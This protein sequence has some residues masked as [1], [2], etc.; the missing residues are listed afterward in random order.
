MPADAPGSHNITK[1]AVAYAELRLARG[2]SEALFAGYEERVR[3]YREAG[4]N[5]LLADEYWLRGRAALALGQYDTALEH[6][7]EAGETAEAQEER[8]VLWKILASLAEVE[9]ACGN[10]AA[11][12]RL[13]DEAKAIV[14]DIADH[15]GNLRGAFVSRPAV[16]KLLGKA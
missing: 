8:A 5:F 2:Q 3:P 7:L 12:G 15:A 14:R 13:R 9:E 6:L 11:A 4:F 16:S 1:V 10:A